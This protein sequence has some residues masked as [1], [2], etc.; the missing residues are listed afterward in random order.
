MIAGCEATDHAQVCNDGHHE[1]CGHRRIAPVFV[2][3]DFAGSDR[4]EC[5]LER[6]IDGDA[7]PGRHVGRDEAGNAPQLT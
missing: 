5:Y 7:E 3:D 1:R 6:K 4:E 2:G